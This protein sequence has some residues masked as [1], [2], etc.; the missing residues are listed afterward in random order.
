MRSRVLTVVSIVLLSV[1]SFAALQQLA[2]PS[3]SAQT[4]SEAACSDASGGFF[5]L[6][7]WYKYLDYQYNQTTSSC[8]VG[9]LPAGADEADW[10][11]TI[12]AVLLAVIEILLFFAGIIAIGFVIYGGVQYV[13][14]QGVPDKTVAAK[15]T[16][17]HGVIGLVIAVFAVAIVNLVSGIFV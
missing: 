4:G 8:E 16:I 12:G 15:N 7:T 9:T 10:G 2:S 14:S 3:V 13:L 17:L 1:F 11:L 5:G 6:P